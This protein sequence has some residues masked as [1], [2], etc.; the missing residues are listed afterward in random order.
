MTT[1]QPGQQGQS[2]PYRIGAERTGRVLVT[3]TNEVGG[4]RVVEYLGIVRGIIVRSPTL[5]QGI[6]GG[7]K[8]IFGGNISE[9]ASVCEA[10]RHEA[11]EQMLVH[12]EQMGAHAILGMRYDATEFAEGVTEVLAYG[13]A[14][15]LEARGANP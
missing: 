3:T 9:Y 13:T 1:P 8:T 12:A 5:G 11:Y 7:F 6:T 4:Y 10:A 15:R 14:V 2:A